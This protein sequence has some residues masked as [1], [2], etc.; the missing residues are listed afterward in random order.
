MYEG[1]DSNPGIRITLRKRTLQVGPF[2]QE[3]GIHVVAK[4]TY[5]RIEHE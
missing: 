2:S 4:E 5:F 3:K 1:R